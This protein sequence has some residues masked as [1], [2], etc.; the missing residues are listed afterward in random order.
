MLLVGLARSVVRFFTI[1]VF[2]FFFIDQL[3]RIFL[4]VI[5]ALVFGFVDLCVFVIFI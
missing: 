1:V 3:G 2:L 5:F 4:V